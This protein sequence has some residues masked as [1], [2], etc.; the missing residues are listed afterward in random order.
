MLRDV[1]AGKVIFEEMPG[2]DKDFS[3][4][5]EHYITDVL[6]EDK[7]VFA[8]YFPKSVKSCFY[9]PTKP[10]EYEEDE[11]K[12]EHVDCYD[13][14]M[15]GLGEVVGASQRIHDYDEMIKLMDELK[16]KKEPLQW[17][18]DLR[19]YG[20]VPHGGGGLGMGRLMMLVTGFL[21]IRDLEEFPRAY[22]LECYA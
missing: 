6:Y 8:R 11:P 10:E 12:I 19:K 18:L 21:S 14:L 22:G 5:H 4:E 1:E 9:M 3:R 20:S 13:L 16:M 2:Y 15:P 17:Y 7:P